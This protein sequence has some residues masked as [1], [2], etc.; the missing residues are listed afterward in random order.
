ME[1]SEVSSASSRK[2]NTKQTNDGK[3][4][5]TPFIGKPGKSK[6]KAQ[7]MP[8]KRREESQARLPATKESSE[9]AKDKGSTTKKNQS[10]K[11]I[12]L[13]NPSQGEPA[14]KKKTKDQRIVTGDNASKAVNDNQMTG[15]REVKKNRNNEIKDERKKNI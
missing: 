15:K 9:R 5:K 3:E 2:A 8:K 1:I 10:N 14:E 13:R 7:E 12:D 4:V 6:E 11:L